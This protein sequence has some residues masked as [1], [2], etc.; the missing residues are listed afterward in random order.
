MRN[1]EVVTVFIDA[2]TSSGVKTYPEL[3]VWFNKGMYV[4]SLSQCESPHAGKVCITFVLRY[5]NTS[6]SSDNA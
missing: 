2:S 4:E 1:Q 3:D 6:T 5:Y